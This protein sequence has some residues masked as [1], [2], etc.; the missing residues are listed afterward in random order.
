MLEVVQNQREVSKYQKLFIKQL[1][2]VC[3]E[4]VVCKLGYQGYSDKR[5]VFYSRKFNF[6]FAAYKSSNRYWN[7]FGFGRP[8]PGGN[9]S[10]TV[11]IN[12]PFEGIDRSI[13]GVFAHDSAGEVLLLHRG[14]IGGG[15][16]GIGKKLFLENYRDEPIS[17]RD[18]STYNEFCLVGDLNSKYL[19][20][21]IGNFVSEVHRIKATVSNIKVNFST[22][23]KFSFTEEK[24]GKSE[25]SRVSK[26]VVERTHGIVVN[27]LAKILERKGLEIGKDVNRDLFIHRNGRITK[28]FEVKRSSASQSLY[29]AVGQLI[30]YSIPIKSPI[31]LILVL[32]D[33]LNKVVEDRLKEL[34]MRV[35]YY[36]W[37]DGEPIFIRLD[38]LL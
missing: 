11:E 15:R 27:S 19:A 23:G 1:K 12:I 14:K 29:S 3:T 5:T 8:L 9:N 22:L 7:A 38:K 17:V 32:P 35:L 30:V 25:T 26:T 20:R 10:I 31:D 24:A 18:D 2:L 21:Q 33:K 16:A 6:W 28:L 4:T 36:D 13:G 37:N 34:G